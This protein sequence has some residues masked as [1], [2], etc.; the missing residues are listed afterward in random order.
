MFAIVFGR[1][2]RILSI[3]APLLDWHSN[4]G[5]NSRDMIQHLRTW[6]QTFMFSKSENSQQSHNSESS[7]VSST[8]ERSQT[9]ND[10]NR[11]RNS[12][13]IKMT[14]FGR[15]RTSL[16]RE[17]SRRRLCVIILLVTLPMVIVEV[18]GLA[19]FSP[20]KT[21]S[22]NDD[23]SAGR[24]ECGSSDYHIYQLSSTAVIVVTVFLDLF[25]A[26]KSRKLPALFN[27][28]ESVTSA[29]MTTL[30]VSL[31]GFA[32]ILITED[33]ETSPSIPYLMQVIIIVN[34]AL[35]LVVRLVL[36]KLRLIWKGEKV[37]ISRMLADHRRSKGTTPGTSSGTAAFQSM[38]S[39]YM[40]ASSV[41]SSSRVSE[42]SRLEAFDSIAAN[43]V[44]DGQAG[45]GKA[46]PVNWPS[47]ADSEDPE[48]ESTTAAN[49]GKSVTFTDSHDDDESDGKPRKR[50]SFSL[51]DVPEDTEQPK[52]NPSAPKVKQKR[53]K[54]TVIVDGQ[55]P[56]SKLVSEFLNHS[57]KMSRVGE[58][59]LSGLQVSRDDWEDIRAS[60]NDLNRVLEHVEYKEE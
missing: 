32:V 46:G 6:K 41:V 33:P 37:V 17:F 16:R 4:K 31:I 23:E 38:N 11:R 59:I 49:V 1:L 13:R 54:P 3:M 60:L 34:A 19:V 39:T 58:R 7:A 50:I 9:T 29:L 35:N 30:F 44:E 26:Q 53:I 15:R 52:D 22:V 21:I 12:I 48:E 45:M 18:V 42:A 20:E 8:E 28:V 56:P 27:E 55:S 5:N 24:F 25:Q 57:N 47:E 40:P 36:P 2:L 10:S 43:E 51:P 14:P